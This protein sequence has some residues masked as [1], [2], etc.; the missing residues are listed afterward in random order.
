MSPLVQR[1]VHQKYELFPEKKVSAKIYPIVYHQPVYFYTIY[2]GYKRPNVFY[3]PPGSP[4]SD[5]SQNASPY[6]PRPNSPN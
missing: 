2:P 1:K 3:S 6:S 5:L 4:R